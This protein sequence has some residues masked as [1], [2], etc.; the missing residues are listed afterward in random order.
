MMVCFVPVKRLA[1]TYILIFLPRVQASCMTSA[2]TDWWA[3]NCDS[4]SR[5]FAESLKHQF[6][7][8]RTRNKQSTAV[9]IFFIIFYYSIIPLLVMSLYDWR[10]L[11][12]VS[13]LL[14]QKM[15]FVTTNRC[16]LQQK[17]ACHN[18]HNLFA[19]KLLS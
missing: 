12:Q 19:T 6:L 14:Q 13:F 4:Q 7:T 10:K 15:C 16:L 2:D 17:Y 11:P 3:Q 1:C 18:K 9:C 8:N 5:F